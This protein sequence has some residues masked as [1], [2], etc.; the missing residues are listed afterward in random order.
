MTTSNLSISL[1]KKRVREDQMRALFLAGAALISMAATTVAARAQ[2]A[3]SVRT[4]QL[5][6]MT[7]TTVPVAREATAG[8]SEPVPADAAPATPAEAPPLPAAFRVHDLSRQ[9]V[10]YQMANSFSL[11]PAVAGGGTGAR[12]E[13]VPFASGG[14]AQPEV[15]AFGA[16]VNVA[17]MSAISV[18]FPAGGEDMG[19]LV[20][21]KR[22]CC[23][24]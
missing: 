16:A 18:P 8:P 9:W 7:S 20:W 5:I 17:Q 1:S 10:A 2:R 6:T 24:L 23:V 22:N 4:V 11:Q 12:A 14:V 13:E 15:A 21:R 3:R 19:Y